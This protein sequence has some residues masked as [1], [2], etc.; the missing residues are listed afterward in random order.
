MDIALL[1]RLIAAVSWFIAFSLIVV[2]ATRGSQA[3]PARW[4]WIA[5]LGMVTFS[6][7]LTIAGVGIVFVQPSFRGV[8]TSAFEPGG[9]RAKPLEPGLHWIFPFAE[10]VSLYNISRR[11]YTM[12]SKQGEGAQKGDDAIPALT[13]DRQLVKI[14][15]SVI[16][17][18]NPDQVVNVNI[19]WQS[20]FEDSVVRPVSRSVILDAV[21]QYSADELISGKRFELEKTITDTIQKK[22]TSQS[23]ILSEFILRDMT[24]SPEYAAAIEQKQIAEQQALQ[25]KLLVEQKRQEAEQAR[26]VAGGLADARLIEAQAEAKALALVAQLIKENPDVLTYQYISKLAPNVQVML[27]PGNAPYILPQLPTPQITPTLTPPG[28]AK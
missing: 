24:F 20:R 14:D 19:L 26:Q 5:T 8:V 4:V 27:V 12:S 28:N 15:A 16:Y 13:K 23:L 1:V 22:F 17:A 9:Y 7:V 25:A 11:T 18:L 2:N 3:Q 6:V 10:T 21:S